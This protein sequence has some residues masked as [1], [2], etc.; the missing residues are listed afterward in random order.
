MAASKNTMSELDRIREIAFALP[1]VTERISHG[2][3]CFFV[4][5]KK[6]LC[7][8]RD[9]HHD[10][11]RLC[12]WLPAPTGVQADLVGQEPHRFFVPPYVGHRGWL[13]VLL[14]VD[15]DWDE[16]AGMLAESYRM[17]APKKLIALLDDPAG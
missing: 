2:A 13:G 9:N 16:I 5:D 11:D 12:I 10:D 1:E 15:P 7:Y 8:F 6:T 17:V 14:N 4:R 3:P